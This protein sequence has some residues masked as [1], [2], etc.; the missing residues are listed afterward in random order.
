MEYIQTLKTCEQVY[1]TTQNDTKAKLKF[2]SLAKLHSKF[3][4][5]NQNDDTFTYQIS[6]HIK[7]LDLY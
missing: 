6:V 3:C 2:F 7:Y 1:I 4:Q 5:H